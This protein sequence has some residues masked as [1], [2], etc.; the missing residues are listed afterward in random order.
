MRLSYGP[1]PTLKVDLELSNV[2]SF[3]LAA[4]DKPS[5]TATSTGQDLASILEDADRGGYNI[6][7]LVHRIII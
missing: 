3:H 7:T 2:P 4:D 1:P 5:R 6:C